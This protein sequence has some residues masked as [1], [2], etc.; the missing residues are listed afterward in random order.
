MLPLPYLAP[1]VGRQNDRSINVP[2]GTPEEYYMRAVFLPLLDGI[3]TQL[4]VRFCNHEAAVLRLSSPLP[5]FALNVSFGEIKTALI[6][7][8]HCY[9][10]P[11]RQ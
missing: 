10:V 9:H 8:E 1:I 3:L 6:I 5:K 7:T 11:S 4:S 2:A